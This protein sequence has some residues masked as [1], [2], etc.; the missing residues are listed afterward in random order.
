MR[1][2]GSEG[3]REIIISAQPTYLLNYCG[4]IT[5]LRGIV[6]SFAFLAVNIYQVYEFIDVW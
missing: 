4:F 2:E 6:C 3:V 5:I 1:V